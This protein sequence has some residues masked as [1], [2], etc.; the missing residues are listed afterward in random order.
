MIKLDYYNRLPTRDEH[1][2]ALLAQLKVGVK[3]KLQSLV[4]KTGLTRTQVLCGLQELINS[5][6]IS[7]ELEGKAKLFYLKAVL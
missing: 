7:F 5:G 2:A 1:V 3:L 4:V 6:V